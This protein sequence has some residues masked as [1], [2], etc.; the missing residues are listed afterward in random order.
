[1]VHNAVHVSHQTGRVELL[2]AGAAALLG[3][4]VVGA[5]DDREADHAILYPLEAL[6]HVVLPQSQTLHYA[7]VLNTKHCFL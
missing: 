6:I 1:M 7:A 5:M 4:G 2:L 3:Q